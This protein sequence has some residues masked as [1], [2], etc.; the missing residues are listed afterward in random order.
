MTF[1]DLRTSGVSSAIDADG[2][3]TLRFARV[4]V[5]DLALRT[6]LASVRAASVELAEVSIRL[7]PGAPAGTTTARIPTV[8]VGEL[9]LKDASIDPQP[10]APRTGAG[11]RT[12]WHVEPLAAL[13]GTLRAEIVDAAW[14]FDA[15][16]TIPIVAGRIDFNRATV[17]HV[18]PDSSMG[19]SRT[20][21]Y[22]DAPNGRTHLFLWSA[23]DLPGVEFERRGIGLGPFRSNARGA[24]ELRPLIEG[25]LAGLQVGTLAT[26]VRDM[27]SRTRVSGE[28]KLG[29][30]V[31]GDE[32]RRIALAGS[33]RGRNHVELAPPAVGRG[34]VVRIPE[35]WADALRWEALGAVV[36]AGAVSARLSVQASAATGSPIVSL[37]VSDL[38]V[39]DDEL[40]APPSA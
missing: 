16:V 4:E 36:T 12:A 7:P 32:R 37:S 13:E 15:D 14:V 40:R 29:D 3:T 10:I 34:I 21:I 17:E 39:R 35:G 9:R 26:S 30:G 5:R 6:P 33:E 2:A 27:L 38:T 23:P 31:V 19:V 22:V 18:G 20:G 28:F 25:A 1:G 24:I 11:A 8:T